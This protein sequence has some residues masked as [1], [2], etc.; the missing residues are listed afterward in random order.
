LRG[1][2]KISKPGFKIIFK[3]FI[4]LIT[5][6]ILIDIGVFFL[7]NNR[8]KNQAKA[9]V[10]NYREL[11]Q[12]KEDMKDSIRNFN[13]PSIKPIK[14]AEIKSGWE[15]RMDPIFKK[16]KFHYG[17]DFSADVGTP[18]YATADGT[19]E[20]IVKP[21][22]DSIDSINSEGPNYEGYGKVIIINHGNGYKTLY[23]HLS[24]FW[25]R[26]GNKVK[27]GDKIGEAGNTGNSTGPHLHYEVIKNGKKVN[28]AN[29]Y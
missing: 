11:L 17:V 27:K 1:F 10:Q 2:S 13:I 6:L 16:K 3:P 21:P 19:I 26:R 8:E 15:Y 12:V 5:I 4:V 28:P 24:K 29:Y 14:N 18:V 25:I 9:I 22:I 7:E 23:G 20:W